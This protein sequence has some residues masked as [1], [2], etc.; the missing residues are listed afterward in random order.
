[1]PKYRGFKTYENWVKKKPYKLP[2]NTYSIYPLL[3]STVFSVCF[4]ACFAN[5]LQNIILL[6]EF[7]SNEEQ[8]GRNSAGL[9]GDFDVVATVRNTV[10]MTH[11][12]PKRLNP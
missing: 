12:A 4:N 5:K 6:A 11:M 8:K 2:P 9:L 7:W 1:M 3:I 10:N